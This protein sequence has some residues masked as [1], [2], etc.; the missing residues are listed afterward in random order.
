MREVRYDW[1]KAVMLLGFLGGCNA[2]AGTAI[3]A[4]TAAITTVVQTDVA[5]AEGFYSTAK[6][7]AQVAEL[8]QPSLKS[9]VDATISKLDPYA[10]ALAA[11]TPGAAGIANAAASLVAQTVVLV[12]QTAQA[13]KAVP[14]K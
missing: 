12:Q 3:T 1:V 5:T 2:N 9:T 8:A 6:G 10:A 11:A 13:V 4:Q 7:I 14:A